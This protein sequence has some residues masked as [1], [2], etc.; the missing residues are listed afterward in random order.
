MTENTTITN[1]EAEVAI[2]LIANTSQSVFL[3]GRAGT[4]KTTLL[5]RLRNGCKKRMVVLAPTG[6]AAINAGGMTIHSFFQLPLTPF[7]PGKGFVGTSKRFDRFNR[8][9]LRLLRTV[10]L[11]VIDEISMVRADLLDAIDDVLRRHRNHNLPFGG[12]QL[13]MIGDLQQLAPVAIEREWDMLRE[14]YSTPYF[15]SSQAL[16]QLP[17]ETVE[18]KQVYRQTDPEF[19]EILN[20]IRTGNATDEILHRLNCR[21]IPGFKPEKDKKYIRLTSHNNTANAINRHQLDLLASPA[22]HFNAK[23]EGD[24]PA[25]AYPTDSDLELKE[26]AQVMFLR[27]EAG[28]YYNGMM[29]TVVKLENDLVRVLPF[30]K[31][32]YIDVSPTTWE[33]TRYVTDKDSGEIREETIGTFMQLPLRLAWAITI[34]KSQ[35]LTFDRAI[36]D[37]SSSFAHGQTYVALSRCRSLEGMILDRPISRSA[38]INDSNVVNFTETHCNMLPSEEQLSQLEKSYYFHCLDRTFGMEELS[39]AF[40]TLHRLVSEFLSTDYPK[41]LKRYDE[42]AT[43]IIAHLEKTSKSFSRQYHAMQPYSEEIDGRIAKAC[44]Y[45]CEKLATLANLLSDTPDDVDNATVAKRLSAALESILTSLSVALNIF[46][47]LEGKHFTPQLFTDTKARAVLALEQGPVQTPA[48]EKKANKKEKTEK[49]NDEQT[50]ISNPGLYDALKK[51][52]TDKREALN[53]PAFV[54]ASNRS[55]IWIANNSPATIKELKKCPGIG[56]AK[57][58]QYGEEIMDV[59]NNYNKE[60]EEN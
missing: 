38:I 51:W 48:A 41:L 2:R 36:I 15:F 19:L 46:I 5:R 26:G 25:G 50:D 30:D 9:K 18:L 57:I 27:N 37:A 12:V 6:V 42:A 49:S 3:T 44:D 60:K 4:G 58:A 40:A 39:S 10:D 55:L 32:T 54:I 28:L 16:N 43:D 11:I 7:I 21:H 24:F 31:E 22:L 23:I 17:Y 14:H 52:R 45:Y 29:G 56:K 34:H 13:L 8:N 53:V 33:N 35:G 59:I 1:R 47:G 20:S